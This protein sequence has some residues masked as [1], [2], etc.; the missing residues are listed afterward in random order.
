MAATGKWER[1]IFMPVLLER[2]SN[3]EAT[4]LQVAIGALLMETASI[5]V[6]VGAT[7]TAS[8]RTESALISTRK[9]R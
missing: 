7:G 4:V 3:V 5:T 9:G 2:K 6:S 8:G 1:K